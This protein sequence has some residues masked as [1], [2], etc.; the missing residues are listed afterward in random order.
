MWVY[1]KKC[2][3]D[4]TVLLYPLSL[5][6][7]V[8]MLISAGLKALGTATYLHKPV[9]YQFQVVFG[10]LTCLRK[11]FDAKKMTQLQRATFVEERKWEYRGDSATYSF[12]TFVD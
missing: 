7:F 8:G 5:Y 3:T 9:S 1:D 6:P 12:S 11:Y 4:I 2:D 10:T